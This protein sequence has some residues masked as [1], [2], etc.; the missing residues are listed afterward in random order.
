MQPRGDL[1]IHYGSLL[2]ILKD[3]VGKP[4]NPIYTKVGGKDVLES[5]PPMA[6]AC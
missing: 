5:G 2:G 6:D 3:T 1:F 4:A